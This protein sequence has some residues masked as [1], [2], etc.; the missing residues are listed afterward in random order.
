MRL[1]SRNLQPRAEAQA[2]GGFLENAGG[3]LALLDEHIHIGAALSESVKAI[4]S[5]LV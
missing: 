3:P 1:F 4:Y 2:T 5:E